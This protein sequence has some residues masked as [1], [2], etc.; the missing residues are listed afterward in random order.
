MPLPREEL[1]EHI[2]AFV[3]YIMDFSQKKDLKYD[4]I[5]GHYW[6]SGIAGRR[7]KEAWD[8]P[9]V[10]MFH[11]LGLM[12][13]RI[14][15]EGESEGDYRIRGE[16]KVLRNA[17]MV[18]AA[19]Q[20]ELAQ[21]QWLYEVKTDHVRVIPPG[22]NLGWFNPIPVDEAREFIDAP[23][24]KR[25]LLF[26]GRIEPLKGIDTLLRALARLKDLGV[27]EKYGLCLSVIGGD[28]SVSES[29]MTHEMARLN[30]L[31]RELGLKEIV[32]FL[33]NK[34]QATLPYY[35]SAAD[36]VVVPSHYESFGMVALEA[37]ACGTPV[38]ASQVGG[39]AYLIQNGET[40]FHVPDQDPVAL[41]DQL[42]AIL[43]DEGLYRRMRIQAAEYAKGFSWQI[44]AEQIVDLYNEVISK[45]TRSS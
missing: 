14:A 41:S 24:D 11:T 2:P 30:K 10:Q 6:M 12:K 43:D 44:I 45:Y 27:M 31:R 39:L 20:A 1:A 32:T 33:G 34:D 17:D 37:M 16:L 4:V 8:V 5:H 29:Q 40:G 18:I 22:V 13:N 15:R 25:M 7:L 42:L 19:T 35:Y 36:I 9:M 28:A 21:L 26:V 3:D 38:V 23:L